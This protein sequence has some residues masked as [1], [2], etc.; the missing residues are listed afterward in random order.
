MLKLLI[1]AAGVGLVVTGLALVSVPAAFVAAGL[2]VVAAVEV[3]A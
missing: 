1:E 3:R 2:A